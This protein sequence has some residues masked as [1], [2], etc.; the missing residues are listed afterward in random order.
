VGRLPLNK[1]GNTMTIE[2]NTSLHFQKDTKNGIDAK[3]NWNYDLI[4]KIETSV[5]EL[6]RD[7]KPWSDL[8][9]IMLQNIKFLKFITKKF[10]LD[11]KEL[12]IEYNAKQGY[13]LVDDEE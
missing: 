6:D 1:K 7:K 11:F 4:N 13:Y 10:E 2:K 8:D 12:Y 9:W 3:I 5:N